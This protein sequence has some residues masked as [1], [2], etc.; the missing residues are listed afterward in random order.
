VSIEVDPVATPT[1]APT[2][3]PIL[4]GDVASTREGV[5]VS[6][7]ILASA[8]D[9]NGYILQLV[10]YSQG[11]HGSVA[12]AGSAPTIC[13]YTPGSGFVGD[14]SFTYTAS[15]GH[16]A[17]ASSTVSVAVLPADVSTTP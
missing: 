14:D 7:D 3:G 8:Y 16:G 9:P 5:P 10:A 12:C 11:A 2:A 1:P 17:T 13:T 4:V 15:D 6:V